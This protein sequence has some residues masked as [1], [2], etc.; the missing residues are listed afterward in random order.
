V[1]LL[2]P[3]TR[4]KI[5]VLLIILVLDENSSRDRLAGLELPES[6]RVEQA[7]VGTCDAGL[8]ISSPPSILI[9]STKFLSKQL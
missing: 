5:F 8:K 9:V 2:P 1:P 4:R 6:Y 7:K 3:T